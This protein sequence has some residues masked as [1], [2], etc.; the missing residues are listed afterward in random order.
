M[1]AAITARPCYVLQM[2][3]LRAISGGRRPSA[4]VGA[5]AGLLVACYVIAVAAELLASDWF[6]RDP[7]LIDFASFW[8][9]AHAAIAGSAPSAYDPEALAEIG[10]ELGSGSRPWLYPPTFLLAVAPFALFS[11]GTAFALWNLGTVASYLGALYSVVP[12]RAT[13]LLG[14]AWP[15]VLLNALDGQNGFLT[16]SLIGGSL[17]LLERRP[18]LSGTLLGLLTIKPQFGIPFA[19][20]LV[21][22]RR[23]CA[24]LSAAASTIAL[25]A[26]SYV[27]FGAE[28]WA[29]FFRSAL[30]SGSAMAYSTRGPWFWGDSVYGLMRSVGATNAPAWMAHGAVAS[31]PSWL[32][33]GSGCGPL[34]SR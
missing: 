1:V 17:A 2:S 9:A 15:P 20:V 26:S 13:L 34:P 8:T 4:A 7:P 29:A 27:A 23:W 6:S 14:L 24:V 33:A 3:G 21:L 28:T 12:R 30:G 18:I 22:T 25:G 16:A 10:R 32:S 11:Y 5:A 31:R 19:I